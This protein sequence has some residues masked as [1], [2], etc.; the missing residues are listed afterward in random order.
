VSDRSRS[1]DRNLARTTGGGITRRQALRLGLAAATAITLPGIGATIA[2]KFGAFMPTAKVPKF[3]LPFRTPPVLTPSATDATT[4]YYE[5]SQVISEVEVVPGLKT[6]IWGYNGMFPGPTIHA[7]TNRRVVIRQ[8]NLLPHAVSV[9]LHGGVQPP[10]SDGYPTDLIPPGG[11]KE[12]VYPNLHRAAT[13]FYHDHAMDRTG[14]NVYKGLAGLY[15]LTDD[16]DASLLLPRGEFD[17]PLI[18]QDRSF[19]P[20]GNFAFNEDDPSNSFAEVGD[21]I[22]INGVPWPRFSVAA[23]KYRL[24]LL[25]ASSTRTYHLGLSPHAAM[26]QIA[27]EGGLLDAPIHVNSIRLAPAERAEVVVDFAAFPVGTTVDLVDRVG[28]DEFSQILPRTGSL[29]RF[30]VTR[31]ATDDSAVPSTLSPTERLIEPMSTYTRNFVFK[32]IWRPAFAPFQWTINGK[33]FDPTVLAAQIAKN[34]VEIWRFENQAADFDPFAAQEHP[35]H[36]HLVNF[37][38]LDR[39]GRPPE[40]FES[41]WKDTVLVGVGETVRVIAEFGPFSGKYVMHCHNLA[42]EDHSM[43]ANF[44]VI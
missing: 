21:I 17:V 19:K 2:S 28:K 37:L 25:N 24:R 31:R 32:P 27:T 44:S 34:R 23:R 36:V 11:T 14:P 35:V 9:H 26:V 41:G 39:N 8:T 40:S 13:L 18:I 15:L 7:R 42:H 43:M 12:Y 16:V 4:D 3:E 22:L 10:E 29:M 20:D 5:M 33:T 6:T 1:I 38:I 30:E